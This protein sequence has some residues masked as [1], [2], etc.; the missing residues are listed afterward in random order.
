MF[1]TAI[2][3][4]LP[5]YTEHQPLYR[6][7]PAE[8]AQNAAATRPGHRDTIK[9]A[10][11]MIIGISSVTMQH[12]RSS[13][14]LYRPATLQFARLCGGIGRAMLLVAASMFML[15]GCSTG[16][17][18]ASEQQLNVPDNIQDSRAR[19]LLAAGNFIAASDRYSRLAKRSIDPLE[20]QD[21]LLIAAEILYDRGL[22]DDAAV[23]L[24]A[25]PTPA[26][27]EPLQHRYMILQA[28]DALFNSDPDA[29]LTSLPEPET[30]TDP[31]H[32]AR[33]YE[34]RS[35]SYRRLQD[36]DA[37]LVSRIALD[38]LLTNPETT[39][40]NHAQIWQLLTTQPIPDLREMTTNV[41]DDVYLGWVELAL[42]HAT[43]GINADQRAANLQQWQTNYPQHPATA[44]FLGLIY[45]P[46]RF[47]GFTVSQNDIRQIA[48]LLPVSAEGIG[49]A[50][51]AVR[52]G[53]VTAYQ[54]SQDSRVVPV[55]RFYDTASGLPI[56]DI[57][58][59]AISDGANAVIGPLR[60][61]A[62]AA[63]ATQRNVPVPTLT[64]N[65]VEQLAS[66]SI[67]N[68]VQFGLAPEDE[69]RSAARRARAEQYQKAIVLQSDDS[70]GDRESRAF[71]QE[72][73]LTG[74]DIIY[75][76]VLPVDEF[77]Y[78]RQI[79]DALL[80][81]QSDQRFRG[82]S[83]VI[84][85]K[86]FFE[87]SIRDDV[88]VIFLAVT[89]EQ[90]RSV[91]PQLSFFRASQVPKLAT[92]RITPNEDDPRAVADL[93]GIYYS[94]SPWSLDPEMKNDILYRQIH[95][96]FPEGVDVFDK[97]YALGIDAYM[98]IGQLPNLANP[99]APPLRGYTGNLKLAADGRI[100][101][102]LI[103]AQFLD[104][105]VQGVE[106]ISVTTP[107]FSNGGQ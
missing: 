82:V 22:V 100:R 107:M 12:T 84:G 74:G 94:D 18:P 17:G 78:S 44:R 32:R 52:D 101:R 57:Y 4:S 25:I 95:E 38:Q 45:D 24:A 28:R 102:E 39:D 51:Q 77:D 58:R 69:A 59:Q 73:L 99:L 16:K 34:V 85:K 61:D 90:A 80:I 76:A 19:R 97:L 49:S 92:S 21:F 35:Q 81:T 9:T 20:E 56:R 46:A 15:Q 70:R 62:V 43:S 33:V 26:L 66:G 106:N 96:L 30:V 5:N 72:M 29:A 105:E 8:R 1:Y 87:P 103:W 79:R 42:A 88:D 48:V 68:V 23:K 37:E 27:S 11:Q 47:G 54:N 55:L 2:A 40:K 64:L 65:Y 36:P 89:H 60:K 13:F 41:G 14:M 3:V 31:F 7:T 86:L 53:I 93:N 67:K 71:Q 98:L 63:I 91:R 83:N 75:T 6:H 10:S 104:G 50:A